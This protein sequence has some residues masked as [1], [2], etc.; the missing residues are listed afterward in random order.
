M[1]AVS[2]GQVSIGGFRVRGTGAGQLNHPT[3][4]RIPGGGI[5]EREALGEVNQN[6]YVRLLLREPDF[7]TSST[8]A[9]AINVRYPGTSKTVDAGTVQ[10]RIPLELSRRATEFVGEI[11]LLA[12]MPDAPARVVINERTGTVI[13]GHNVRVSAV[14][15]AQGNLVIKPNNSIVPPPTQGEA[16]FGTPRPLPSPPS[17][18]TPPSEED[19]RLDVPPMPTPNE[20]PT[21]FHR[22]E[23]TYTV[24]ELARILN[25]LGVSPRDLIAI[26]QALK[27]SGA[28]HAELMVM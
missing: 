7:A 13:V 21:T 16:P 23:P 15:I 12:V 22:I 18:L 1:Y 4:G 17:L 28:L 8:I 5:V 2:Q 26:F 27:Q 14:A 9:K 3:V 10:I 11:G 20:K 25:A 24:A 6:G 19:Q